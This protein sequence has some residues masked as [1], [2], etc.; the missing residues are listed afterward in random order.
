VVFLIFTFYFT[1]NEL[2]KYMNYICLILSFITSFI[3]CL[4]FIPLLKQIKVRQAVRILGPKNHYKKN[5]TPT[6][7]GIIFIISTLIMF[8][9]FNM[10]KNVNPLE[11]LLIICPFIF[12]G[13]VGFLDDYLKV[14]R[15]NN[16]GLSVK[17][18][19][20]LQVFFSIFFVIIFYKQLDTKINIFGYFI[21]FGLFYYLFIILIF[22]ST[23]NAVNIS[24]GLDG[25]VS[26]EVLIILVSV[27]F[28][29]NNIL[30]NNF[31]FALVGSILGF[32]CFNIHPAKI[33]MGDVGSLSIGAS[34][35]IIFIVLKIEILLIVF[36]F[37]QVFEVIS[38]ILQVIYFK[39][40]KGK[41]LFKMAPF[42]HHLELCRI[43]EMEVTIIL[44]SGTLIFCLIGLLLFNYFFKGF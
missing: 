10:N 14:V 22:V 7:G 6:M 34:L 35:A 4:I 26:G 13:V 43:N 15:R 41:R 9:I 32:L 18:K 8:L 36:C 5:G 11:I 33:F 12:Y 31:I 23:T 37:I 1:Y 39:I 20:F 17:T 24:D 27:L 2:V 38:V 25:L 28:I 16:D 44:W 3:L 42:H 40:T 29:S 30:I 21:D 19:F